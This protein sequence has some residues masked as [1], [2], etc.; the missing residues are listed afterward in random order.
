MV[1]GPA[2]R[3]N[4]RNYR[5][6]NRYNHPLAVASVPSPLALRFAGQDH[7]LEPGREYLLGTAS[8]CDLQLRG[9]TSAPQHAR[10]VVGPDSV[11]LIDLGSQ[12][13]TFCNGVRVGK[14]PLA[15]GDLLRIGDE[16]ALIVPDH[17]EGLIVPLPAMRTAARQRRFAEVRRAA[18]GLREDEVTFQEMIA[19]ELRRTPWFAMSL[20]LHALLLLLLWIWL[21]ETKTAGHRPA[22]VDIALA[23]TS[24]ALG[25]NIAPALEVTPEKVADDAPDPEPVLPIEAN[26]DDPTDPAEP[27]TAAVEGLTSNPRI[28][29]A[30][31][32]APPGKQGSS[33]AQ[34]LG[35]GTFRQTVGDLR[36]SGL[37]IVFVFDSTGSM[38]RTILDTKN[39]ISQMLGVL[40]ALVPDARIS[41]VTYRDRGSR[42]DY[43]V[44]SVPLSPDFWRASN[45]VQFVRAEGGGD[46]QEDVRA[47]LNEA[48]GQKWK[49]SARRVVILAGDAPPH[50]HDLQK[51][52]TEVRAFTRNG[53]SFV[54]TLVT[55]PETAGA[56]TQQCFA[57]IAK[58]GHGVCL[59][60]QRHDRVMQRVLTLA[61]GRE[62][63][64]DIA[65]VTESIEAS[66][67][68]TETWALD[69]ARRGGPELTEALRKEPVDYAL[70]IALTRVPH[71]R[72]T[73]QLV[74]MLADANTASHSRQALGW[75]L[76]R[77]FD[78]PV[79]PVDPVADELPRSHEIERLQRLAKSLPE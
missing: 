68:R 42:E 66:A 6:F 24:A 50:E 69:L 56:D 16:E 75:V 77:I 19:Q 11:L 21:G 48:F 35:S 44:K 58:A 60:M 15:V 70:L 1:A 41:L 20:I 40:R 76:Q 9:S 74:E 49:D 38:S 4:F 63:D 62:F 37:E 78:L 71:Q 57:E 12:P 64:R 79:P 7:A 10:L 39:T 59:D 34:N 45:F 14:T 61:F 8:E 43:L 23:D 52:L 46:R 33:G 65:T 31:R 5:L 55:S 29:L 13:G 25:D 17:G 72:T 2:F 26:E 27:T 30:K 32:A 18:S 28:S 22:A 51:L 36:R 73:L 47:G 54:H 3:S 67:E 53:R